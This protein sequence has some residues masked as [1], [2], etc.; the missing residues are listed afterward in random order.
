MYNDS[1][2][3]YTVAEVRVC[4]EGHTHTTH[5]GTYSLEMAQALINKRMAQDPECA[6]LMTQKS[7]SD[8]FSNQG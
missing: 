8:R 6:L 4:S 3:V 5:I 2:C 1:E 7:E